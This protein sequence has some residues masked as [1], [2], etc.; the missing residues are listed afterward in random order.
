[1]LAGNLSRVIYS[2]TA[3]RERALEGLELTSGSSE[4][5][6][7]TS[8]RICIQLSVATTKTLRFSLARGLVVLLHSQLAPLLWGLPDAETSQPKVMVEEICLSCGNWET[9][10]E[11]GAILGLQC[12]L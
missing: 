8:I 7:I 10:R 11:A 4:V 5:T 1:M 6:H 3:E 9:E 12:I 2:H